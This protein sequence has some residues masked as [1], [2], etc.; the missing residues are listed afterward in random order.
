M[1]K[2]KLISLRN[3]LSISNRQECKNCYNYLP[4]TKHNKE[5]LIKFLELNHWKCCF[6]NCSY[7][8]D[9][10]TDDISYISEI[11]DLSIEEI[12]EL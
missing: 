6:L 4:Q 10:K 1:I 5:P 7:C 3:N 8:K 9:K 11:T 12:E 2:L